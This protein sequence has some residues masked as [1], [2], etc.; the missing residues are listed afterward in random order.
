MAVLA[1]LQWTSANL[2]LSCR[3]YRFSSFYGF[4][5][6]ATHGPGVWILDSY[7]YYVTLIFFYFYRSKIALTHNTFR[8]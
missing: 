5:L 2:L 8:S 7:F 3:V 4:Y 6:S 1:M